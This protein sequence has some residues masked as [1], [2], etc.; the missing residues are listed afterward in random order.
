MLNKFEPTSVSKRTITLM[1][2]PVSPTNY[3]GQL[4]I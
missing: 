1:P 2:K 3:L 4:T